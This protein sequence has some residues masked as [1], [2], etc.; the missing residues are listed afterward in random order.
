MVRLSMVKS[1]GALPV[2]SPLLIC[3]LAN[4]DSETMNYTITNDTRDT[5]TGN[6]SYLMQDQ[7]V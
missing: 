5:C 2:Y 3:V 7:K 6:N 4:V 1:L